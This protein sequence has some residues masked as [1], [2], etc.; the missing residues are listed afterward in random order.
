MRENLI[1]ASRWAKSLHEVPIRLVIVEVDQKK[2]SLAT[3]SRMLYLL[4]SRERPRRG[5]V[6]AFAEGL[7][8]A[9]PFYTHVRTL[10]AVSLPDGRGEMVASK[11][12]EFRQ[13]VQDAGALP[14]SE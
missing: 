12:V 11:F 14:R 9:G 1:S 3:Q 10:P 6:C 13:V 2:R 8:L 4:R 5:P 7:P